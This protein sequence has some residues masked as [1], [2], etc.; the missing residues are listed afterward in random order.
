M[1]TPQKN[2]ICAVLAHTPPTGDPA[3]F[4][5]DW[6]V[7][8]PT[9]MPAPHAGRLWTARIIPPPARW[10][11]TGAFA[12]EVIAPHRRDYLAFEGE[13]AGG[14]GAVKRVDEGFVTA[15]VWTDDLLDWQ[16]NLRQFQGR[17]RITR[18]S[19]GLWRA[20]VLN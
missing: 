11:Q 20:Q 7:E 4:H 15:L 16:V 18:Q 2:L 9:A 19:D 13:I 5:H 8:P 3:D 6:L 17:L 1:T 10:R 12:V 14:R